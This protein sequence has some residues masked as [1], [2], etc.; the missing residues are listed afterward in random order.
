MWSLYQ[1]MTDQT[2]KVM[3]RLTQRGVLLI[4]VEASRMPEYSEARRSLLSLYG[5]IADK[6]PVAQSLHR[7]MFESLRAL[8]GK[9]LAIVQLDL[10][11]QQSRESFN[12][13]TTWALDPRSKD[14][15]DRSFSRVWTKTAPLLADR[16]RKLAAHADPGPDELLRP[17]LD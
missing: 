15:L 9:S 16:F 3:Q 17:P 2:E 4:V 8:Y 12:V 14:K 13:Y 11:A 1:L 7:R 10:I 5:A 6:N